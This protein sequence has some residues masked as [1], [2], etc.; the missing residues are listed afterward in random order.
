MDAHMMCNRIRVWISWVGRSVLCLLVLA[1]FS[2]LHAQE[3]QIEVTITDG[4]MER[5]QVD[6]ALA[7][8][9]RACAP[10]FT[11]HA[12]D[13]VRIKAHA[14]EPYGRYRMTDQKWA[15]EIHITADVRQEGARTFTAMGYPSGHTL[16]YFLGGGIRPGAEIM[17]Q[18]SEAACG[19]RPDP[20][21]RGKNGFLPIPGLAGIMPRA[22]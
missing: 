7:L 1:G 17:K 21:N 11:R 20:A 4:I 2:P 5:P 16:H 13:I 12:E 10:L 6:A 9:K 8:F 3:H 22:E 15:A 19:L 14:H 18:V